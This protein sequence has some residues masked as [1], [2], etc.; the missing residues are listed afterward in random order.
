ML[1]GS[2]QIDHEK[3]ARS[4][5]ISRLT[6]DYADNFY[7]YPTRIKITIEICHAKWFGIGPILVWTFTSKTV[8]E[9][10][11]GLRSCLITSTNPDAYHD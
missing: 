1:T 11:I 7:A 3:S 8:A 4:T 6:R 9:I 10:A 2:Q 5:T